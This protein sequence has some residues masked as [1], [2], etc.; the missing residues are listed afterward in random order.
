MLITGRNSEKEKPTVKK[1][2][3]KLPPTGIILNQTNNR[4]NLASFSSNKTKNE[5]KDHVLVP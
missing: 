2:N 4:A 1:S 3:E 5:V